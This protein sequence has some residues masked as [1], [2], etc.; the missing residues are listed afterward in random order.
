MIGDMHVWC[1]PTTR[2]EYGKPYRQI[3]GVVVEEG[4]DLI[5]MAVRGRNPI[6]VALFGSTA[7]HVVRA[8]PCPVL[9]VR[10]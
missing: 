2:L 8:A 5:V 10:K 9:T 7:N 6:D 1:K 4:A 3:L